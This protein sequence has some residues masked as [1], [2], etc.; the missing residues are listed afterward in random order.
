MTSADIV[1]QC[2]KICSWIPLTMIRNPAL[3]FLANCW[4]ASSVINKLRNPLTVGGF[5]LQLR[6]PFTFCGTHLQLQNPEQIAFFAC[7]GIRHT[8][9]FTLELFVREIY[10]S[11][12]NGIH[13]QFGTCLKISFWNPGTRTHKIVRPASAKFGVVK[14]VIY[15]QST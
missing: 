1:N 5:R 10:G 13:L 7:C 15:C 11:F 4:Y 8:T 3:A 9:K 6:I 12:K 14:L 2:F